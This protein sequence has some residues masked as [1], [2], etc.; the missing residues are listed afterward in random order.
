MGALRPIKK[1]LRILISLLELWYLNLYLPDFTLELIELSVFLLNDLNQTVFLFFKLLYVARHVH[2]LLMQFKILY[3]FGHKR[4]LFQEIIRSVQIQ[5]HFGRYF[6]LG[7][8]WI[9]TILIL[10][11]FLKLGSEIVQTWKRNCPPFVIL[12][13]L[14]I[15][16]KRIFGRLALCVLFVIVFITQIRI[17]YKN[18]IRTRSLNIFHFSYKT[19]FSSHVRSV[20]EGYKLSWIYLDF[21]TLSF[22]LVINR[23][24]R[25]TRIWY[26]LFF[27]LLDRIVNHRY[28]LCIITW[29]FSDY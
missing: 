26:F 22:C 23:M 13:N 7:G 1:I 28:S 9:T 20:I 8:Q 25:W 10:I 19:R 18:A 17:F 27:V 4:I 12:L 11:V 6:L 14:Q 5:V 15:I 3:S 29:V 2:N 21:R 24:K 16:F